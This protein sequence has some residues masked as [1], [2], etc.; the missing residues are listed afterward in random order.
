M[1]I[2]AIKEG[3]TITGNVIDILKSA[4][5]KLPAGKKKKEV[6]GLLLDAEEKI[7]EAEARIAHE[8]GFPICKRCWPPSIMVHNDE[9]EFICR[10]CGKPMPAGA[11]SDV[12]AFDDLATW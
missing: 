12:P 3:L 9:G 4:K 8:L 2:Q 1:N 11:S 6:E 5:K 7:K 10:G